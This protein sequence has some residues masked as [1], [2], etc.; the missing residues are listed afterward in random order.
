MRVLGDPTP[1]PRAV[2]VDARGGE[3]S[4][5]EPPRTLRF[6]LGQRLSP[7]G[8]PLRGSALALPNPKREAVSEDS[9]GTR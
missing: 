4:G 1:S 2:A 3:A 7:T 6:P 8:T 5:T 9:T